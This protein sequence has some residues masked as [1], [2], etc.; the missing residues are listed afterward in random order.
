VLY[1]TTP[2]L[3][4][5]K[6]DPEDVRLGD[7]FKI[8]INQEL[9]A[10]DFA[11][12]DYPDDE[13]IKLNGGRPGAATAPKLIRQF[14]YKMTPTS[15]DYS[16]KFIDLGDLLP[17]NEM[18]FR[19]QQARENAAKLFHHQTRLISVGGGHDYGF[20]DAAAFVSSARVRFKKKPIVI[21]FDAHLDV[22]PVKE[23]QF[24]SGTPFYRL[25][26]EFPQD[27]FELIEIGLQPQCNSPHHRDWAKARGAK[28]FYLDEIEESG[29][30]KIW[31]NSSLK[32]VDKTT[33]VYVSFDIDALQ[34]A[35][36][37]GASQ[38]WSSG[39][40]LADCQKFLKKLYQNAHV[41]GFGVYEVSP[42]FDRDFQTSKTAALLIHQFLFAYAQRK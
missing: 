14:L 8:H 31:W 12:V 33:P 11:L 22:R 18:E 30:E 17:Q 26:N 19:H 15:T 32:T 24:H 36:G 27:S 6:N 2:E 16:S 20:S 29:W 28:L 3:F 23:K 39:L 10:N 40:S 41:Q 4:F 25:L 21:N 42:P 13:G 35:D 7:L 9:G 5:S 38:A 37:G 1:P 34:A